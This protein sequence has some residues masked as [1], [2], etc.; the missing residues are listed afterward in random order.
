MFEPPLLFA[1]VNDLWFAL[2]LIIAISMV[3]AGTRH[4]ETLEIL[5]HF[6]RVAAWI[7][8]FMAVILAVLFV[9]SKLA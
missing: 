3:Y 4:E 5:G 1:R 2:P 6:V 7:S 9:V 8:G